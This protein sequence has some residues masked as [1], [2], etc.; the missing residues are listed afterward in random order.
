M[1]TKPARAECAL[2]SSP[3]ARGRALVDAWRQSGMSISAFARHHQVKNQRIYYW[4]K[5]LHLSK[6]VQKPEPTST[7]F[8]QIAVQVPR[9][10]PAPHQRAAALEILLPCGAVIRIAPGVDPSL[11]RLAVQ[12]LAGIPC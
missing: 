2:S 10:P 9:P 1:D 12:A 11:L 4:S 3:K 6:A 7:D 8:V 5:R